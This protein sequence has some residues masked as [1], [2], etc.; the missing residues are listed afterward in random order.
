MNKLVAASIILASTMCLSGCASVGSRLVLDRVGPSPGRQEDSGLHDSQGALIV[1]SAFDVG[2]NSMRR[3]RYSDYKILREDGTLLRKVV[4]DT[5]S[6]IRGDPTKVELPEGRYRIVA[7]S[8]SYGA[9]T[10]PVLI[11]AGRITTLHLEGGASWPDKKALT[12]S[13]PVRLPEGEIV[14]WRA[15]EANPHAP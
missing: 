4:N 2:S 11:V 8:N 12:E 7:N 6:T 15:P 5:Y 14:G 9:V 10:V 3:R 1:Y 13:N